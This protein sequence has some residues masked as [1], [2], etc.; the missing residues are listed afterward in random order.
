MLEQVL[1][2][3]GHWM[4]QD[5]VFSRR[6]DF[7]GAVAGWAGARYPCMS[8]AKGSSSE[9]GGVYAYVL[10]HVSPRGVHVHMEYI[11]DLMCPVRMHALHTALES[12]GVRGM[13]Y[14]IRHVW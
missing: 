7:S 10:L 9:S 13:T 3:A 14:P 11:R 6:R 1:R 2:C 8:C 4:P 5:E 12:A